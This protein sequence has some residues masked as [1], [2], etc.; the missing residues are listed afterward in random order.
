MKSQQ[1]TQL[2]KK[3][4]NLVFWAETGRTAATKNGAVHSRP[5]HQHQ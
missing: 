4:L 1:T 2:L 5:P 3:T